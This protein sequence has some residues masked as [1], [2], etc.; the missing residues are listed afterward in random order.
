M[1]TVGEVLSER[2]IYHSVL[3]SGGCINIIPNRYFPYNL[4]NLKRN[5]LKSVGNMH[6]Q[7]V[8][9]FK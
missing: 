4:D 5:S 1:I 6:L 2:E 8:H 9:G 3:V 7:L